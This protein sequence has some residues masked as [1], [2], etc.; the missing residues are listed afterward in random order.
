MRSLNLHAKPRWPRRIGW[1]LA[2]IFLLLIVVMLAGPRNAFGPDAPTPRVAPPGNVTQLEGW[3]KTSEAA[4]ADLRPGVAKQVIWQG[5]PGQ[6]AP[7]AVVY[8][9]GFTAT[10]LE[11]S[12]LAEQVAEQLGASVF[13]TRLSGHGRSSPQAMGEATA[14]DWLADTVE[15]VRIGRMLGDKVLVIACSTGATLATWLASHPEL[16]GADAYAF[17][18]PNY[19]PKDKRSELINGPWG[20]SLAFAL[21]GEMR[22]TPS[23]NPQEENAWT[24]RYPT[25]ALFPM[26]ALVKQVRDSDVS[27]FRAPVLM[28][29]SEED[30]TVDPALTREVFGRIGS[31]AKVMEAVTYSEALGQHVLAGNIRAPR[32]TPIMASRI[33]AWVQSLKL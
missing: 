28:L 10:R 8:L 15:A 7:W 11:T 23:A 32:A 25:R 27:Q 29:Y 20:Q 19:G 16:T 3:L 30:E 13:Y 6:R 26:M 2:A 4:Y 18:S 1:T 5:Q 31:P 9:H 14:Q 24:T 17:V 12:P 21:E 33:A 22:G